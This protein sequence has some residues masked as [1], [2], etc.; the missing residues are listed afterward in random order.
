VADYYT[1][2]SIAVGD[3]TEEERA[4]FDQATQ[5]TGLMVRAEA[6]D[7]EISDFS[8]EERA[9]DNS[10]YLGCDFVSQDNGRTLW[11][12]GEE[13]PELDAI[14]GLLQTYLEKFHPDRYIEMQ[15]SFDAS[16]P[17]LDAYGGG[18]AF[19]TAKGTKWML[20]S[21]WL[22]QQAAEFEKETE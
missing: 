1:K 17:R 20:T 3:V 16:K 9:E 8:E 4:W 15:Y 2:V 13:S 6:E 22:E 21:G 7:C 11:I 5:E 18:A 19:I 14:A 12:N 10:I